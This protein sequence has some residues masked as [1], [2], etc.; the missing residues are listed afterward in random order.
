MEKKQKLEY[1]APIVRVTAFAVEMGMAGSEP[2]MLPPNRGE[3]T[4]T[5]SEGDDITNYF[6][7]GGDA[8]NYF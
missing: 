1:L 5:M 4:E 7:S 2:Q 6:H 8:G 3:L